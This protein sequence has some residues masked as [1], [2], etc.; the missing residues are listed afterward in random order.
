MLRAVLCL[1]LLLR[2]SQS[3]YSTFLHAYWVFSLSEP[4]MI[5]TI[6]KAVHISFFSCR[7][8]CSNRR[9]RNKIVSARVYLSEVRVLYISFII[10]IQN[11]F[12]SLSLCERSARHWT[13]VSEKRSCLRLVVLQSWTLS[14]CFFC[15]LRICL[16]G[17]PC[18]SVSPSGFS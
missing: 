17:L 8:N 12:F 9:Q 5:K 1:V 2:L 13:T 11:S 3:S 15:F 4:V 6:I 10:F 16:Y 14:V 18:V 7:A